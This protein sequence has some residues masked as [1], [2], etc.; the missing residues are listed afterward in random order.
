LLAFLTPRL[1][2]PGI[3]FS[4]EGSDMTAP[5]TSAKRVLDSPLAG[6]WY[7]ADKA[8]L[9][10]EIDGYMNGA[11][12]PA[13]DGVMALILPHAG[14]RYSGPVAAYGV[15]QVVGRVFKRV[16]VMGP[17]HRVPMENCA[18]VPEYT[19]YA[20]PLGSVPLDTEFI[21]ALKQHSHFR[22]VRGAHEGEHSVQIEVPLLQRALGTFTLVPIV[23]GQLDEETTRSM[24]AILAGLIGPDTL[25][26]ASSD[27]THYGPN[28]RY[29]PF[30]DNV[31][32]NLKKMDLGA[33][34]CI[35]KKDLS[36]FH[37]YIEKT[38]AT[39]C[40]E[41]P[42]GLLLAMAP[43]EARP[44]LLKYDTSGHITSDWTNSVSYLSIA[45]TGTWNAGEPVKAA[46]HA[47]P[48]LT[49]EDQKQLLALARGTL[50]FAVRIG[51]MPK[52]DDF[53][54]KVTP[55]MEQVMGAFVTLH[56]HGQ[57][58]GC[59]G[60][61]FPR[62]PLFKA[63][64]ENAINA[65]LKDP[66][67]EPVTV[68]ELPMLEYEISALTPPRAVDSYKDIII[69]RDGM[70]IE[71]LGRSAVYLPQVA[72]EQGWDLPTTLSHLSQKAG[73]PADAWKEG[74]SFTVFQAI[75]IHE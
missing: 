36:A 41:S 59:I 40:G 53:G 30:R 44:H 31:Q 18:S 48:S 50:E 25:V 61:I 20:T 12:A 66:R 56:Q 5:T 7:P 73:L 65:G 45:F 51:G 52:P 34:D 55:G 17:S 14:Y 38:G 62:R 15:K 6:Q 39:V 57:L 3:V 10:A 63:V 49:E 19:D 2:H 21:Q 47:S 27:F 42:I 11:D 16:V 43:K 26:V 23:V 54:I 72:P 29:L 67:F 46:P 75:V 68:N 71:K 35:E 22:T 1:I 24:G 33:W 28:Y 32:E 9:E 8:V 4:E 37:A 58:R 69:G 74:A 70:V 60:E 64:M 13:L